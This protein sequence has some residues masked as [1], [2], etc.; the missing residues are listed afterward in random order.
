MNKLLICMLSLASLPSFALTEYETKMLEFEAKK[1]SLAEIVAK[2]TV[3]TQTV[4]RCLAYKQRIDTAFN[5]PEDCSV[6]VAKPTA[7]VEPRPQPMGRPCN[8][9][10]GC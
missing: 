10:N 9:I 6:M 4:Q 2:S 7:V 5:P 8:P 3:H 1:L